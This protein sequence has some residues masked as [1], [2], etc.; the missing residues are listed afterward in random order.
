[1]PMSD[2]ALSLET[3]A[4]VDLVRF[5]ARDGLVPVI[6][7]DGATGDVVMFAY[8]NRPALELTLQ[9]KE[10]HY[11]SRSR[12]ALWHKGSTSG[13]VQRLRQLWLDCDRDAV[14]A[15]VDL[16]GPACHTG[17][18]SCFGTSTSVGKAGVASLAALWEIVE[19]RAASEDPASYTVHLLKDA[20]LRIKKLGEEL[21]ELVA[22][23]ASGE[24]ER[25]RAEAADLLYHLL[26]ALRGA[27]VSLREVGD[28]LAERMS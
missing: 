16:A 18:A 2:A 11:F 14:L 15:I 25:V 19:E 20:N 7:Q 12:Q 9:T 21:A 10:M 4:D 3:P 13:N 23:I 24:R 8:A 26:V 1:M 22:A 5:D 6:V 28:E 27:Q 17:M